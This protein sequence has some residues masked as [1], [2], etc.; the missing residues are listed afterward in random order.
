MR[1][2]KILKI[3]PFL[4]ILFTP[5]I[6]QAQQIL[7]SIPPSIKWHQINT[8]NF[9]VLYQ[10]DYFQQAQY[11]ANLLEQLYKPTAQTLNEEP[12]KI[13]IL[14]QNRS[15]IS[16]GFVALAPRRS[17]FFTMPPQDYNFLGT[18]QWLEL[19]AVHELRHVVQFD[20]SKTGITGI[21]STLLG[22]QA[23]AGLANLGVPAWFW[24]GDAVGIETGLTPSGRGRIPNFNLVFRTQLLEK[25]GWD[26]SKQYLRSFQDFVPNHYLTGYYLSTF[27]RKHHGPEAWSDI[28]EKTFAWPILPNR[29]SMQMRK[30]T[31][32]NLD[33]TYQ[34]MKDELKTL[35]QEQL[36]ELKLTEAKRLTTILENQFTE[37]MYP[38]PHNDG[39]IALQRGIGD[40]VTFVNVSPT[41]TIEKVYIPGIFND[42]G[43]L[44]VAN[45]KI[46]WSEYGFNPRW[47]AVNYSNIKT[48]DLKTGEHKKLTKRGRFTAPVLSPDGSKIAAVLTTND[49]EYHL[50]ILDAATGKMLHQHETPEKN[51]FISMPRWS[52]T[53]D[54]IVALELLK[55]GQKKVI[56][57]DWQT[58]AVEVLMP[59]T[60][61]NIGH[62]VIYD[63]YLLYNSPLTGIDNIYAKDLITNEKFQIT[64]RPYAAYNP[65]VSDNGK[66]LYFNDFAAEGMH[67]AQMPFNPSDWTPVADA[68]NSDINYYQVWVDQ[69]E[70]SNVLENIPEKNYPTSRYRRLWHAINP[71]SWGPILSTTANEM[72]IGISSEDILGTT[73]ISGGYEYNA[74]EQTSNWRA[75]LSYQ[76]LFPILDISY[77]NR[78]QQFL[79]SL[80]DGS[81]FLVRY[82]QDNI[83]LG[84]RIPLTLTDSRYFQSLNISAY[85][86]FLIRRNP[87]ASNQVIEFREETR[88]SNILE[89]NLSFSSFL[90]TSKRD[91]RPKWGGRLLTK[92]RHA[93]LD[94][95]FSTQQFGADGLLL[96]PGLFKHHSIL[97]RGGY[98]F[99]TTEPN[100]FPL[101]AAI[102]YPRG[103]LYQRF[104]NLFTG[105]FEYALPL[106][107]PDF[108]IGKLANFQRFK[109]N[110]FYDFGLGINNGL[111]NYF[112]SVGFD[113][114]ADM[115]FFRLLP[116]M[117]V[118]IRTAYVPENQSFSYNLILNYNGF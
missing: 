12:K 9:K 113:F 72:V 69:E 62:P 15:S 107:Y 117:E 45:E 23:Q 8:S 28:T 40:I 70:N 34:A 100:L 97:T 59:A 61:E 67:V 106:W 2:S 115:N 37:Y 83:N 39:V 53:G 98:Q 89:Y 26:Y 10:E 90:K 41:G 80:E 4:L 13:S 24:E 55:S 11:T 31:G 105:S 87:S 110:L 84:F 14:L 91:I 27:V 3:L 30:Q 112:N 95:D 81:S 86:R 44:S 79:N 42:P 36:D 65:A 111:N 118:G 78:T 43:Q 57:F 71:H 22:Q 114:T 108:H 58:G 104:T 101:S 46:V 63:K 21:A 77:E 88:S 51:N 76:A 1:P 18:N 47:R 99:E 102:Q 82:Q 25:G 7:E 103:Y 74:I 75:Q 17:E 16:N 33:N 48:Y 35:W 38:Q 49:Q 93:P 109:T 5:I 64:S 56:T 20:K 60:S 96:F 32:K 54:K 19:L 50:V 85:N 68:E 92:F 6:S 66:T 116:L 29:F 52:N 94:N 73:E